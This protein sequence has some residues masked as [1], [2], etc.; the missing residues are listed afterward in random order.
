VVGVVAVA[1]D[2]TVVGDLEY[3]DVRLDRAELLRT[4]LD[5]RPDLRAAEAG[6][7]K[8]RADQALARANAWWDVSPQLEYQRD[9]YL[10]KA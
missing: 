2:F 4:A 3:R 10:P 5:T 6:R 8:A 7:L 9:T 1:P